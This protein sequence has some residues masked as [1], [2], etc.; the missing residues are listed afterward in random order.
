MLTIYIH[1]SLPVAKIFP[2]CI[3]QRWETIFQSGSQMRKGFSRRDVENVTF[4]IL[5]LHAYFR[6][7]S[8]KIE[9]SNLCT[10]YTVS[11]LSFFFVHVIRFAYSFVPSLLHF[12]VF[13]PIAFV[14]KFQQF[15]T[16][17]EILSLDASFDF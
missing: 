17:T 6:R 12:F 4:C 2:A 5:S 8:T 10:P 9:A 11:S 15:S 3:Y 16:N 1:N 13:S 7:S 14:I